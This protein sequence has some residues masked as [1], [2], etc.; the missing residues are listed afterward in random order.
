MIHSFRTIVEHEFLDGCPKEE[1]LPVYELGNPI[2][3]IKHQKASLLNVSE[4]VQRMCAI[5]IM[6]EFQSKNQSIPPSA[7]PL[8][9]VG[10]N[11]IKRQS[12]FIQTML[13]KSYVYALS[14]LKLPIKKLEF[15]RKNS[16]NSIQ[17]NLKQ[18]ALC[19]KHVLSFWNEHL[20]LPSLVECQYIRFN[21]NFD[22]TINQIPLLLEVNVAIEKVKAI[23]VI[24]AKTASSVIMPFYGFYLMS[25]D[26][27]QEEGFY[28]EFTASFIGN[29]GPLY[30]LFYLSKTPWVQGMTALAAGCFGAF[31]LQ[32]KVEWLNAQLQLEAVVQEKLV[33]V[34]SFF[35]GMKK[36]YEVLKDDKQV[37]SELAYFS[38]LEDFLLSKDIQ[39]KK[40]FTLL[41]SNTLDSA[42]EYYF[43]RGQ[44]MLAWSMMRDKEIQKGFESALAAIAE[45]D[46]YI[47]LK[48]AVEHTTLF[49]VELPFLGLT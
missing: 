48:T 25:S 30:S 16:M 17:E 35:K 26:E 20:F 47:N 4:K 2:L 38:L 21:K 9:S 32:G 5:Q 43:S 24:A 23:T 10:V 22:R 18:M 12:T 37:R 3:Y 11:Q 41:E 7:V 40:I 15:C 42:H 31:N 44:V 29:S 19:E 8:T 49:C 46:S 34:A 13:G 6:C 39:L 14:R 1:P 33:H 45:I 28:K 36:I 27:V